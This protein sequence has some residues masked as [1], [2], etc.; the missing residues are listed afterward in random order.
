[1]NVIQN[2]I[3]CPSCGDVSP[4]DAKFCRH[5]SSPITSYA[6]TGPF[7]SIF[8]EGALYRAAISKP[9]KPIILIGIWLIFLPMALLVLDPIF[10]LCS[11]GGMSNLSKL[12]SI[13]WIQISI[14]SIVSTVAFYALYLTTRNY[15]KKQK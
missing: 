14:A 10:A 8:A 3:L 4:E 11:K 2:E 5:C 15:I 1:M 12:D 6:S 9:N 7:E 13:T